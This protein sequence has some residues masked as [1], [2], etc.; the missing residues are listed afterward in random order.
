[1]IVLF[2]A[3]DRL[4]ATTDRTFTVVECSQ[5]HLMRLDPQ[6]EPRELGTYYPQSYWFAP[7]ETKADQLEQRYRRMVL[8]DHV[9]FVQRALR[10]SGESGPVLD[11]GC[12]GG[13]FLRMMAERGAPV[14]G[15]DVSVD[16]ARVALHYNGV[17]TV[18]ALLPQ[19]PLPRESCSVVTMFHLLEH[20]YYPAAYLETARE[21]LR[22]GGRLV[23][24]VPNAACWQFL[25]FGE[26]WNGI[27]VPRHLFN[28][29]QSDL[30]SL[31]RENGFVPVRWKQFS[32]RDNPAGLATTLAPWLDPMSR[33]VRQVDESPNMRLAKDLL[34]SALVAACLPFTL[35][36]AACRA[37]STIMIEARKAR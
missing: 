31:I 3:G 6:P 13:L 17:P 23:V 37:G 36:E 34:Y 9:R 1:M 11:I 26:R 25:L 4:Y 22:P 12:G 24:Q 8:L 15:L 21:V 18:T 30:D 28:F 7:G 35:L 2:R 32:L 29:R 27:D 19:I 5:C 33:R 10:N 20:L 14:V 16:A